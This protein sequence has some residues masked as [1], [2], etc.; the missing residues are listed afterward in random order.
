MAKERFHREPK[1]RRHSVLPAHSIFIPF[2]GL[3]ADGFLDGG[4]NLCQK[5]RFIMKR[6]QFF[7][8]LSLSALGALMAIVAIGISQGNNRLQM[9]LQQQ[10]NEIN[11][12]IRVQQIGGN[13][14]R[15]MAAVAVGNPRMRELLARHGYSVTGSTNALPSTPDES[16]K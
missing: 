3:R 6:S 9:E 1:R 14:L 10:Q 16:P 7:T 15:D 11:Q 4:A 13:I 12:G 5:K 2:A 8:N